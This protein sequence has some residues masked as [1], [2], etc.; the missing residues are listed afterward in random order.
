ML[1]FSREMSPSYFLNVS[2]PARVKCAA[3]LEASGDSCIRNEGFPGAENGLPAVSTLGLCELL[4]EARGGISGEWTPLAAC[5]QHSLA[6]PMGLHAGA[7]CPWFQKGT[8]C[9]ELVRKWARD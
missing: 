2:L 5:T 4:R 9:V 8:Q 3:P 6:L 7:G 1:L